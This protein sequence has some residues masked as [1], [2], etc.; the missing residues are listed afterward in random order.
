MSSKISPSA[1]NSSRAMN[2]IR[3]ASEALPQIPK[4]GSP[5]PAQ[6]RAMTESNV[7]MLETTTAS[8]KRLAT[9]DIEARPSK[10]S[11]STDQG[12]FT[13]SMSRVAQEFMKEQQEKQALADRVAQLEASLAALAEDKRRADDEIDE[14]KLDIQDLKETHKK[15]R[16]GAEKEVLDWMFK[17]AAL[18]HDVKDK[19]VI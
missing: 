9:D 19:D 18:E 12:G 1:P 6:P 2:S 15:I 17:A 7:D 16:D 14:L 8:F 3:F 10:R 11:A 4:F 5:A 13:A